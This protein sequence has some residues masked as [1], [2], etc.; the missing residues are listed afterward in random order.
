MVVEIQWNTGMQS[1][2]NNPWQMEGTQ[3]MLATVDDIFLHHT[4]F[5]HSLLLTPSSL[6]TSLAFFKPPLPSPC[7]HTAATLTFLGPSWVGKLSGGD[8]WRGVRWATE[9]SSFSSFLNIIKI[10]FWHLHFKLYPKR[11]TK[12]ANSTAFFQVQ[13]AWAASVL[14]DSPPCPQPPTS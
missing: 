2:R 14:V 6:R 10:Q 3:E 7:S 4:G 9:A 1:A 13:I 8:S 12:Y 5:I 11:P